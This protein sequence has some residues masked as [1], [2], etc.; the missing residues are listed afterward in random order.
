MGAIVDRDHEHLGPADAM[1]IRVRQRL[2]AAARALRDDGAPPPGVDAP[3]LYR[4]R[5]VGMVL[6]QG[7]DWLRATQPARDAWSL[8]P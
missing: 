2:L 6:P 8:Q 3:W 5:P 4:V 7:A 1:I